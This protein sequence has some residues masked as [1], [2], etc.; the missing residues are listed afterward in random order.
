[1]SGQRDDAARY[2]DADSRRDDFGRPFEFFFHVLLQLPILFHGAHL[3]DGGQLIFRRFW[4]AGAF[5][6][7]VSVSTPS[8]YCAVAAASSISLPSENERLIS[9]E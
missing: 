7:S 1:M 3:V 4:S 9:P 6:G 5:F 2:L 8:W